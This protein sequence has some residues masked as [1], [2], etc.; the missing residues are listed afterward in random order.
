MVTSSTRGN[1][2]TRL[3]RDAT[4]RLDS[5]QGDIVKPIGSA[6]AEKLAGFLEHHFGWRRVALHDRIREQEAVNGSAKQTI[7][8]DDL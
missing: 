4:C 2:Q 1:L 8:S 3:A 7:N 6:G 5:H